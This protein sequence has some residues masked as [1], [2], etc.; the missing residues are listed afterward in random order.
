MLRTLPSGDPIVST[1]SRNGLVIMLSKMRGL[2]MRLDG[3]GMI[4]EVNAVHL[5]LVSTP[6]C[7]KEK[8]KC[9]S[10]HYSRKCPYWDS[11]LDHA[12]TVT[13]MMAVAYRT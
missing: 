4:V 8:Y 7:D 12:A 11:E 6:S 9:R 13:P 1:G 2:L 3:I 5:T 10:Y